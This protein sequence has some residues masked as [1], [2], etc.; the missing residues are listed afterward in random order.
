MRFGLR[1]R[2]RHADAA[3]ARVLREARLG[4]VI[5]RER[6]DDVLQALPRVAAVL[7]AEQARADAAVDARAVVALVIPQ[8]RVDD[9]RVDG[10]DRDVD[11][12]GHRRRRG[13]HELPGLAAVVGAVEAALGD[14]A[15]HVA[16]R[17]R[18]H[19]VRVLRIDRDPAD[20]RAVGQAHVGPVGAAVGG[21]V[22]AVAEVGQAAAGR[23]RLTGADPQRAV[24]VLGQRA[25]R[26]HVVVG[27]HRR[28]VRAAVDAVPDAAARGR[29]VDGVGALLV[30]HHVDDAPADV[31]R[32]ELLPVESAGRGRD[33]RRLRLRA[34]DLG[35][36]HR[37]RRALLEVQVL[38]RIG[39][40]VRALGLR[41]LR[42]RR[43]LPRRL[44]RRRRAGEAERGQHH[45]QQQRASD[46]LRR[47]APC[48]VLHVR[49]SLRCRPG[50]TQDSCS[51]NDE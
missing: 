21:L 47:L 34:H 17:R 8:R 30:G 27:P 14:R 7:G 18:E 51:R 23:V 26:L 4:L 33:V 38:V 41:R 2:D 24:G 40:P 32:A 3:E 25:H 22:D 5:G 28:P 45:R 29:R 13:E 31:V 37:L 15:R 48:P 9:L 50:P 12:A 6:V 49:A 46:E 16:A 39:L 43:D 1:R 19:A 44:M 36:A 11:R 10:V 35:L 42:E 20:R